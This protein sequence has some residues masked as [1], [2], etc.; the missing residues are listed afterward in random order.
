[1][2]GKEGTLVN[3]CLDVRAGAVSE[4]TGTT[5]ELIKRARLRG[6]LQVWRNSSTEMILTQGDK[7]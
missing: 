1:M 3:F 5:P 2:Q 7:R 4:L 6:M